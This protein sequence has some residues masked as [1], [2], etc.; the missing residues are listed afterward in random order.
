MG[1]IRSFVLQ[2]EEQFKTEVACL[3]YHE[4]FRNL[5]PCDQSLLN[6][7]SVVWMMLVLRVKGQG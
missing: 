7:Q 5:D 1:N 4:V 2:L 6:L 3:N